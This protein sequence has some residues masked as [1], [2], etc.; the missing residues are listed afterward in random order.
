M[1]I[2]LK[3]L[4]GG[5]VLTRHIR[6]KSPPVKTRKIGQMWWCEMRCKVVI[7]ANVLTRFFRHFDYLGG[8][9]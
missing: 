8:M 1:K 3:Q 2:L 7:L 6:G 4:F 9:I 5:T